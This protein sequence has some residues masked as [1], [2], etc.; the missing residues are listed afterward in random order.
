MMTIPAI[1]IGTEAQPILAPQEPFPEDAIAIVC[2]G[3]NY[4]VYQSDDTVPTP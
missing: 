3:T 2:D 1:N 4:T